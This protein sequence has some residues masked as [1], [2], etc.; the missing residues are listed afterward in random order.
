V[1]AIVTRTLAGTRGR[2][3]VL[4]H[5]GDGYDAAGDRLQTAAAVPIVV[6]GLRARHFRLLTVPA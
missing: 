4:L 6:A 1:D 5:D 3:I 2:S